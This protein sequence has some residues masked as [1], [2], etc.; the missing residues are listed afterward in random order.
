MINCTCSTSCPRPVVGEIGAFH[1]QV[2][3]V[4]Y[5]KGVHTDGTPNIVAAVPLNPSPVDD[6]L[7][8]VGLVVKRHKHSPSIVPCCVVSHDRVL[9]EHRVILSVVEGGN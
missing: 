4:G 1:N 3:E 2:V 9:Y 5:L 6:E 7:V 8:P